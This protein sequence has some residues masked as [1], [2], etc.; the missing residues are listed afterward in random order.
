MLATYSNFLNEFDDTFPNGDVIE[1]E[2]FVSKYRTL[3]ERTTNTI[4][5]E[6]DMFKCL[7]FRRR[8]MKCHEACEATKNVILTKIL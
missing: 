5:Q 8:M 7:D 3:I 6:V 1:V 2:K 4:I